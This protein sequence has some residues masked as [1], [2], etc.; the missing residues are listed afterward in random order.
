[1][2]TGR[3]G[4][5]VGAMSQIIGSSAGTRIVPGSRVTLHFSLLLPDGQEFD[6]TRNGEPATFQMGDGNLLPGFEEA[7]LGMRAGDAGQL[8]LAPEQAFGEHNP[9][10][11][12]LLERSR[13][14]GME[15]EEGLVVS[16]SAAD[17]ELPGVVLAVYEDTVKVDFNHPLSGKPIIFDVAIVAVE[18][19]AQ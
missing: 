11:V 13:F 16:F 18:P 10:N 9:A 7:L 4:R 2:S 17:G 5:M 6:T 8:E 1:M 19:A 12:R 3:H 15:L 14:A